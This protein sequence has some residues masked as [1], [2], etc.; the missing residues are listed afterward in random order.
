M[1]LILGW[2]GLQ[3]NQ[4]NRRLYSV[5]ILLM[6]LVITTLLIN[7]KYE[8]DEIVEELVRYYLK[9]QGI[10]LMRSMGLDVGSRQSGSLQWSLGF[11]AQGL[12]DYSNGEEKGEF[13]L[14]RL[15]ELVKEYRVDRLSLVCRKHGSG[16]RVEASQAYGKRW[17]VV[18]L[19]GWVSGRAFDDCCRRADADWTSGY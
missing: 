1:S 13:G 12:G 18:Q 16:P 7:S 4:S 5:V 9:E 8:R 19:A 3:S 11:T 10:D 6:Y 15:S 2:E 17:K 14:D